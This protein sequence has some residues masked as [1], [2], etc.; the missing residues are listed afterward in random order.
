MEITPAW[1]RPVP[2]FAGLL[3]NLRD[4]IFAR[5]DDGLLFYDGFETGDVSAWTPSSP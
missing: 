1:G 2:I 5:W 3:D 4:L